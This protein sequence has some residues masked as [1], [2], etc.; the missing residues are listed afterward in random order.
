M[1]L[2]AVAPFSMGVIGIIVVAVALVA[3]AL[4]V[5]RA[6]VSNERYWFTTRRWG[7]PLVA[8]AVAAYA[9]KALA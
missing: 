4:R 6:I 7:A 9:M 1:A 5:Q 3:A 2:A 8:V